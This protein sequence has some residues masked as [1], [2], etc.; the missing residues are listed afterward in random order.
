MGNKFELFSL[1]IHIFGINKEMSKFFFI[2]VEWKW[3]QAWKYHKY[4]ESQ[5]E[6]Q[7]MDPLFS[8]S[9][10]DPLGYSLNVRHSLGIST[11]SKISNMH[12]SFLIGRHLGRNPRLYISAFCFLFV[13]SFLIPSKCSELKFSAFFNWQ[14]YLFKICLCI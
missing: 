2:Q 6:M 12:I 11:W 10:E 7:E 4:N 1:Q 9:F 5:N 8:L 14:V 3:Q 13:F